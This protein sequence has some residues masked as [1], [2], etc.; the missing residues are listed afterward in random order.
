MFERGGTLQKYSKLK[1]KNLKNE[2]KN[3]K[4]IRIFE[5]CRNPSKEEEETNEN[6][7]CLVSVAFHCL[8]LNY[9]NK[10]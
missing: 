8:S 5:K 7:K 9:A 1:R 10:S 2:A 3:L 4:K 6:G